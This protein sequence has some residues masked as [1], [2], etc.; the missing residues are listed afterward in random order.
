MKY[1]LRSSVRLVALILVAKA[2]VASDEKRHYICTT[3]D[4]TDENALSNFCNQAGVTIYFNED[5]N[6]CQASY[7]KGINF[8]RETDPIIENSITRVYEG[9]KVL[10]EEPFALVKYNSSNTK[11]YKKQKES[12]KKPAVRVECYNPQTGQSVFEDK[13]WVIDIIHKGL[14]RKPEQITDMIVDN[15]NANV[16]YCL[17]NII[18]QTAFIFKQLLCTVTENNTV[19]HNKP[20]FEEEGLLKETIN[21]LKSD[22]TP[23]QRYSNP[24]RVQQTLNENGRLILIGIANMKTKKAVIGKDTIYIDPT[25]YNSIVIEYLNSNKKNNSK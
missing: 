10:D 20:L 17:M 11:Q 5:S 2:A 22:W 7:L 25:L 8:A 9:H 23:N 3:V 14:Q 12:Y 18:P 15:K 13:E 21:K 6:I 16:G 1:L 24:I 4:K 19:Y